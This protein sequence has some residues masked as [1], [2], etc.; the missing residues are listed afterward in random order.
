MRM[1]LTADVIQL[2]STVS[3]GK[4]VRTLLECWMSHENGIFLKLGLKNLHREILYVH[5]HYES[6]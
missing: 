6:N 4:L 5:R 1:C 3:N 2:F